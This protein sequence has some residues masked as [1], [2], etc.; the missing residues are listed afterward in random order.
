MQGGLE[1]DK[2]L[3]VLGM[4]DTMK[5]KDLQGDDAENRRISLLV[6]TEDAQ[7]AIEQENQEEQAITISD[8][9]SLQLSAAEAPAVEAP[10]VSDGSNAPGNAPGNAPAVPVPDNTGHRPLAQQEPVPSGD[11]S[12]PQAPAQQQEASPGEGEHSIVTEAATS[13]Q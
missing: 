7:R 13:D 2:V 10:K 5:L 6:L 11:K 9:K 3:R 4:A 1:Q 12:H 8:P